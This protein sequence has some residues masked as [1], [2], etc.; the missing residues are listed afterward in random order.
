M[1]SQGY[2][3]TIAVFA[4]LN[5]AV[6]AISTRTIGCIYRAINVA[7]NGPVVAH[8][9]LPVAFFLWLPREV[10]AVAQA[11][12]V[13]EYTFIAAQSSVATGIDQ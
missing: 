1:T 7:T 8:G 5:D 13:D 10:T 11:L 2:V 12:C 3:G 4:W 6:A 9:G